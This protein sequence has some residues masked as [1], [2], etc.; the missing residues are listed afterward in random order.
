MTGSFLAVLALALGGA[1][2]AAPAARGPVLLL[3]AKGMQSATQPTE[4]GRSYTV[5]VVGAYSYNG[6]VGMS[7]CGHSDPA[8]PE[9]WESRIN[10][11]VDGRPAPCFA[12]EFSKT[13]AYQWFQT[14]TGHPFVFQ[15]AQ[16]GDDVGYLVV[17]VT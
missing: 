3:S 13:H 1:V 15:I 14:G 4:P 9:S 12:Q 8:G 16:D 17:T 11:F 6:A 10:V 7:D 2:P 5:T